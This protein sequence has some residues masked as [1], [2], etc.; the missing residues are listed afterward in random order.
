MSVLGEIDMNSSIDVIEKESDDLFL[1]L[2]KAR[3]CLYDKKLP[4]HHN[5]IVV[6]NAMEEISFIMQDSGNL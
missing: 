3:P 6:E 4:E 1:D 2:I 5:K